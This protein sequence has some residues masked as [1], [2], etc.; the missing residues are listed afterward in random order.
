MKQLDY[1]VIGHL[2]QDVAPEGFLDGG[3]VV[4]A[5]LAAQALGLSVGLVTS[6]GQGVDLGRAL[7][8]LEWVSVPALSSTI[9]ENIYTPQGRQQKIHGLAAHLEAEDVPAQWRNTPIVHLAPIAQELDP[10]IIHL[11]PNSLIGITPQGWLREWDQTGQVFP[12]QWTEAPTILPF[13]TAVIL[14]E[15]DLQQPQML[16]DYRRYCPLVVLTQGEQGCTLFWRGETRHFSAP[17][18]SVGSLTG[19]GDVFAAAFLIQFYRS[20]GD[21]WAAADFANQI[22]SQ[23]VT[24]VNLPAKIQQIRSLFLIDKRYGI[25]GIGSPYPM[26]AINQ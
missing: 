11:F 25:L 7:P 17:A 13:A 3:T 15:E 23:S 6:V 24:Q 18:V 16:A 4:Y 8:G 10:T 2:A 5:G 12:C 19:A 21:A 22:A 26:S 14:S 9:F 1:L 20:G